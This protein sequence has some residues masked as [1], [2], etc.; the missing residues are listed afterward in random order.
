MNDLMFIEI[1]SV[2][3]LDGYKLRLGFNTGET[4]VVDLKNQLTGDVFAPLRDIDFFKQGKIT[5]NTVEWPN[6][7]DF[8]PEFLYTLNP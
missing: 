2:Q 6:G 8:A 4:K 3:H 5:Y 1:T 7:A